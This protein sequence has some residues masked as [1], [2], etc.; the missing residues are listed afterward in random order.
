M[1]MRAISSSMLWW[2]L[3]A[4][5]AG[6]GATPRT[7]DCM[8]AIRGYNDAMRWQRLPEAAGFIAAAEREAFLD[9]QEELA[10]E[11][12]IDD[13]EVTRMRAAG[14]DRAWAQVKYT[15]HLDNVGTVNET[16]TEQAWERHG[17]RWMMAEERRT[18]GETMP[19]VAEPLDDSPRE[20]MIPADDGESEAAGPP[21]RP[22]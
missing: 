8:N 11:L 14:R 7:Q 10:D 1:R 4:L 9:E 13:Y 20:A 15:W 16:T 19:G 21:A 2:V 18:R 17:K 3:G 5:V 6:C 22:E 12:R